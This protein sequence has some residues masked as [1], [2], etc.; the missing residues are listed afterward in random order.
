MKHKYLKNVV[1]LQLD[2][3][4][5]KGCGMCT[6]VCPHGVFTINAE[7]A[8]ITDR[9]ACMECGAC[10]KNC[11]FGAIEVKNGVG[12]AAAVIKGL[13]TG[14]EPTCGCSGSSDGCCS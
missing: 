8:M 4:K 7:K 10:E 14:S 2:A 11:P 9:D 13:L 5:C 1:T 3:E 12:C 6:D